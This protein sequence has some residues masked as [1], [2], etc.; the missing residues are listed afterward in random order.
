[1]DGTSQTPPLD[2]D[3]G[4]RRPPKTPIIIIQIVIRHLLAPHVPR[5]AAAAGIQRT[6]PGAAG[7]AIT[8]DDGPHP[9]GTPAVLELLAAADIKATFFLVGEQVERRPALVAEI[10]EQGHLIA[11]HG[12]RH[13]PQPVMTKKAVQE[14]LAAGAA[15]LQSAV[16]TPLAWHRPPYGLYS[17]AGLGAIRERNLR[18][19]LWSRWGK[20]WRR[21]TT[22][23]GIARR[24]TANLR[25]GDVILLHDADFYSS[26]GSHE[27]TVAALELIVRELKRQKIGTVLPV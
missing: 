11:L 4:G 24:A 20:D 1:L 10:V 23:A 8:F 22:P 26:R 12:Y 18:P 14:D 16:R 17:P 15:A 21:L 7:V 6:L 27:R 9:E 3:P 5:A 25:P 19:L 2:G 13:R